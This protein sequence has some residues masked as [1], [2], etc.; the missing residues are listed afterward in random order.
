MIKNEYN[1]LVNEYI[2]IQEKNVKDMGKLN[3][4]LEL[5]PI[6]ISLCWLLIGGLALLIV[7]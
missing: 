3:K 5:T 1:N 2:R 4:I 6:L 7:L